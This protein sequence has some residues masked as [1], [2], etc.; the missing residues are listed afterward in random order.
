MIILLRFEW[1][2]DQC[3]GSPVQFIPNFIP[4][5]DS[6]KWVFEE[7]A[8]GSYSEELSPVYAF[9]TP[10]IHE[11]QVDVW[12]SSGQYEHTSREIEIFPVPQ[13]DLG[14]DTLICN[15][16]SVTLFANCTADLYSWSTSQFGSP[17]ITVT[18]S[19]TYWVKASFNETGC[20]GTDTIHVGFYP[21]ILIDESG[22][23]ITPT[24]CNGASGS[25]T[26]LYALG[27]TP[28]AYQWLDLSGNPFGTNIDASGLPAG[29][30]VSY[31]Y[32]CQ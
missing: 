4:P 2:G 11:V 17:E 27:P 21:P 30:Y 12:Y 29:Q 13:P 7:F 22:L 26:G 8:P 10:G 6:I 19:G 5:I 28:L 14:P 9:Q 25:I 20:T 24:S 1:E 3:Q 31:D 32:G 18:D 15:G 16:N 23:V